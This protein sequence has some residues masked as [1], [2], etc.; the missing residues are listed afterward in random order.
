MIYTLLSLTSLKKIKKCTFCLMCSTSFHK[1]WSCQI[2]VETF[3]KN[4]LE[5]MQGFNNVV[6]LE[7]PYCLHNVED[8]VDFLANVLISRGR[9][10][11]LEELCHFDDEFALLIWFV[12]VN[13][14]ESNV[15]TLIKRHEHGRLCCCRAA[16]G[17][18]KFNSFRRCR[19]ML[20]D[21]HFKR[22]EIV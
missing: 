13:A 15:D 8:V 10:L 20:D 14:I 9:A 22:T 19:R 11:F 12:G 17:A 16:F 5:I 3:G 21:L 1:S 7:Q 4:H 2:Q 6:T 18:S